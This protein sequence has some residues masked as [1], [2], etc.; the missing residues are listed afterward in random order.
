MRIDVY[1]H[2]ES[3]ESPK[4]DAILTQLTQLNGRIDK[5]D[6]DI[7]ALLAEVGV[8]VTDV[9]ALLGSITPTDPAQT[10]AIQDATQSLTDLDA[11]IKAALPTPPTPQP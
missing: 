7:Q 5:M 6:K 4:L 1:V 9:T 2:L 11:K 3:G 8:V 10:K